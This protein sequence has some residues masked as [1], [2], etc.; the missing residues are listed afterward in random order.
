MYHDLF[1]AEA[2]RRSNFE[3]QSCNKCPPRDEFKD[4]Y[5]DRP[6]LH[7]IQL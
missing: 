7:D 6:V 4:M 1:V 3:L 5:E 2:D